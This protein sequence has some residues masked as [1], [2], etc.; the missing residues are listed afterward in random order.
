MFRFGAPRRS[1]SRRLAGELLAL[2]GVQ[3]RWTAALGLVLWKDRQN[4]LTLRKVYQQSDAE[5][6]LRVVLGDGELR[7]KHG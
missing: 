1:G 2:A 4:S 6:M 3:L 5:T 7:E